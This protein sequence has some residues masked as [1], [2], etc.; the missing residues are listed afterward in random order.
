MIDTAIPNDSN[1]NKKR[2]WKIKQVQ[3]PGDH[4]Q[5]NVESEDK[6]VPVIIGALRIVRR[7]SNQNLW[8]VPGHLSVIELHKIALMRTAHIILGV[9]G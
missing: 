6:I 7:G 3:K 5:Q 1:V 2:D 9:L 8:F 4:G